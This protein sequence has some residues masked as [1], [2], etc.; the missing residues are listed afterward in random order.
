MDGLRLA[1]VA[2][3][4]AI[5]E[6]FAPSVTASV[7]SFEVIAPGPE[8]MAARIARALPHTPWLVLVG[9]GEVAGYAYASRHRDPAAYQWSVNTSVYVRAGRTR[10]G[11]GRALYGCLFDLLRIQGFYAAHAGIAL[12]NDAS[13]G[14][15]EAMGFRPIGVYPAVGYKAGAWR[16]V[17]WWQ[18]ALRPRV[19][20]PD[21]PLS[22]DEA[23][24]RPA[25]SAVLS[26]SSTT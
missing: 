21:P 11:I 25:W 10:T 12:P 15:H 20:A 2:D 8:D 19:G 18:L 24:A 16:D 1:T 23:R 14:L 6:I 22:L 7:T 5:A 4:A 17:G 13:V 3:A 9:G 26:P